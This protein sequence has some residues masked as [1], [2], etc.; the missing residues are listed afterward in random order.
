MFKSKKDIDTLFGE[1]EGVAGMVIAICATLYDNG[2]NVIHVGGLCRLLGVAN[3][4]AQ[5]ND[6]KI[7]ELPEDF[8][9]QIEEMGF[10]KIDEGHL[11][12]PNKKLLH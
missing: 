11:S 3:E 10:E 12:I 9:E 1:D 8:Y 2:I 6:D 4:I 5:E 7:F